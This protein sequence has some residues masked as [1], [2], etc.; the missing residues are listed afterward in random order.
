MYLFDPGAELSCLYNFLSLNCRMD[1]IEHIF[2]KVRNINELQR[3]EALA[4]LE[5][6]SCML[7]AEL[8]LGTP[9]KPVSP[10]TAASAQLLLLRW[11]VTRP[12]GMVTTWEHIHGTS[13]PHFFILKQKGLLGGLIL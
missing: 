4:A 5:L 1:R 8:V 12:G 13:S 10:C 3:P 9:S 11:D 6:L 7:W 2:G